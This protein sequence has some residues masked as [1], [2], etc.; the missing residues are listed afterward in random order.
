VV[1]SEGTPALVNDPALVARAVRALRAALGEGQ[2]V[3]S[4]REMVGEDFSR[5]GRAG[6][7]IFM[8]RL[9]TIAPERWRKLRAAGEQPPSL[10]SPYYYPDARESLTT[11]IAAMSTILFDLLEPR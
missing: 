7:P 1:F 11:G 9:G 10:H 2:V 8:F 5:Y 3:Q 4:S 6:V